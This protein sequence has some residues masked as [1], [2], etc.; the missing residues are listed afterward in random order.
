MIEKMPLISIITTV[1]NT[2]KYV[3]RCFDSVM[4]QTYPNLE[5]IVVDNGSEGNIE[6]IVS[7]YKVAYPNKKIN[8]VR[9]RE[10]IGL[11]HG[12]LAGLDAA[13]G[14]YIAF[15]DS[16]DRVSL[17]YYRMLFRN[18]EIRNADMVASGVVLV[19]SSVET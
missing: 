5:F 2:E 19:F 17:D 14:E 12:R 9:L 7:S 13:G 6:E 4:N 16:D 1:Y 11:F 3:E 18:L 15:I 10:N 8:L